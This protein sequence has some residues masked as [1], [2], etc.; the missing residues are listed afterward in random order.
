MINYTDKSIDRIKNVVD[1]SSI[2]LEKNRKILNTLFEKI[3]NGENTEN[4]LDWFEDEDIINYISGILAYDFEINDVDKAI[5]DIEKI[6]LKQ[7]KISRRNEIINIL[8]EK[9]DLQEDEKQKLGL[10]L[11]NIIIELARMK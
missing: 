5:L 7:R 1:L 10:E 3:S 6:Y 2:K 4:V 11:N 8:N 9:Q